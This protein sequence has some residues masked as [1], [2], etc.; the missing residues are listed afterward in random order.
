MPSLRISFQRT[1]EQIQ[2]GS[3]IKINWNQIF[4]SDDQILQNPSTLLLRP[5]YTVAMFMG[6]KELYS[7]EATIIIAFSVIDQSAFEKAWENDEARKI[8]HEKQ[9]MKT[10]WPILRQQVL[11]GMTRLGLPGIPLPWII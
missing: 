2:P 4:A 11:D 7:H 1:D 5:K 8:F 3:E 9:I 6:E 10:L